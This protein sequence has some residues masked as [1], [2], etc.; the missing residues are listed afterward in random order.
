MTKK[1]LYTAVLLVGIGL[2]FKFSTNN[3]EN[4]SLK[5]QHAEFF[6]NHPYQKTM[7]LAKKVR[8]SMGLPP[9]AF[10]EQE[11]LHEMSPLTGK[12]YPENIFKIQKNI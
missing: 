10:I 1:L 3:S 12:T 8:K 7:S 6:N 9:N 11:F 4:E 2:I 5:Q